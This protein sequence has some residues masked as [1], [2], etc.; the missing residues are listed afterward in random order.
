MDKKISIIVPVYKVEK[1][2]DECVTSIVN[3]TYKNMEIILINDGSPDNSGNMCDEW[4]KK[5]ERIVVVHKKNGGLSDARNAGLKI[6]QGDYIGFVD[7]DDYIETSFYQ[8]LINALESFNCSMAEGRLILYKNGDYKNKENPFEADRKIIYGEHIDTDELN[9]FF[10]ESFCNKLFKK[11]VLDNFTFPVDEIYEDARTN[12]K[13]YLVEKNI[14]AV[15]NAH[16]YYRLDG[17]SITRRKFD[18][19]QLQTNEILEDRIALFESNNMPT[20]SEYTKCKIVDDSL[21]YYYMA[22]RDKANKEHIEVIKSYIK[23]YACV[24]K[25]SKYFEKR[26]KTR[27]RIYNISPTLLYFSYKAYVARR[28][29]K[30]K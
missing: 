18:G 11:E 27:L 12:Y 4:A 29:R 5:D 9:E 19:K 7:S 17:D 28:D 10:G 6:A 26:R 23:K 3:Q 8:R 14:A 15:P 22:R 30:S 13:L 20:M 2:L 24:A 25:K 16:Y 1:Y 21:V